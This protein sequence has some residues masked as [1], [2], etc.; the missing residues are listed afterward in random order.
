MASRQNRLVVTAARLKYGGRS[1]VAGDEFD[2]EAMDAVD[3]VNRRKA[4]FKD[5]NHQGGK[6]LRRD[7]RAQK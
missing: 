4:R 2:C 1:F 6:Y 7:M 5:E 3:F